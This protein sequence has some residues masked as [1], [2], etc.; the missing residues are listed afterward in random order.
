MAESALRRPENGQLLLTV[1]YFRLLFTYSYDKK[2]IKFSR[3]TTMIVQKSNK[4]HPK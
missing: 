4:G 3:Y 1:L 2:R